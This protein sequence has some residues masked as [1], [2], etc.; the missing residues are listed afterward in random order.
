[1]H[2]ILL[3]GNSLNF[4]L[5]RWAIKE[6]TWKA[7]KY[8]VEA[9]NIQLVNHQITKEPILILEG[10][11]MERAKSIANTNE[12]SVHCSL[13]HEDEFVTAIVILEK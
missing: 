10:D 5:P 13:S 3:Q 6:A 11:A 12:I 2:N 4:I 9:R 1:M 7:L 8:R